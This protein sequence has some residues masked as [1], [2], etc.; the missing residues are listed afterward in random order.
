MV[1]LKNSFL[2]SHEQ[3]N[4]LNRRYIDDFFMIW[5]YDVT[6]LLHFI[7]G[8]KQFHPTITFTSSHP[9]THI[10]FLDVQVAVTDGKLSMPIN[11]KSI[12]S[13]QYLSFKTSHPRHSKMP[14]AYSQALR[15]HRICT[16][17]AE[18]VFHLNQLEAALNKSDYP[19]P[20]VSNAISRA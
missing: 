8:F 5:P 9:T 7:D 6:D 12:G 17:N 14:I 19:F 15:Y 10:N 13:Q 4:P 1:V 16:D 3:L 20:L 18:L 2:E 11:R